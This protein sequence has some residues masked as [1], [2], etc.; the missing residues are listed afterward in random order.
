M[1]H[2]YVH[3]TCNFIDQNVLPLLIL[4]CIIMAIENYKFSTGLTLKGKISFFLFSSMTRSTWEKSHFSWFHDQSS[5]WT[6]TVDILKWPLHL[7]LFVSIMNYEVAWRTNRDNNGTRLMIISMET[8]DQWTVTVVIRI[9][10]KQDLFA[11]LLSFSAPHVLVSHIRNK[12]KQFVLSKSFV[13][14]DNNGIPN[15]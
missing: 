14:L 10:L 6:M 8:H 5:W 7:S 3:L 9:M 15:F 13:K 12:R 4:V 2:K 1:G 11:M